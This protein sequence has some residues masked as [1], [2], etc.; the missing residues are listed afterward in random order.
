MKVNLIIPSLLAAGLLAST[1]VL[2]GAGQAEPA[3]YGG[4]SASVAQSS[5][6]AV[7]DLRRK[8]MR[9]RSA[10]LRALSKA[11]KAGK[12]GPA[13]IAKA[14]EVLAA[15]KR[16]AGLF[17][18]RG[19]ASDRVKGRAKPAIWKNMSDVKKRLARTVQAA[20]DVVKAAK[21]GD[22]KGVVAAANGMGCNGC[23]RRYRG[24]RPK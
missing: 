9:N 5:A 21:M 12:I 15:S 24:P 6:Q 1:F 3:K 20:T 10:A 2:S 19:T 16:L 14:E 13:E 22:A 8:L 17:G 7:S 18:D 23:H 11:A 4:A